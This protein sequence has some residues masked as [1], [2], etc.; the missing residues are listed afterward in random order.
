MIYRANYSHVAQ[1]HLLLPLLK[2]PNPCQYTHLGYRYGNIVGMDMGTT[3]NT[4]G[5]PVPFPKT[6]QSVG[7]AVE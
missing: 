3:C 6:E 2:L 4:H 1:L 5:L 7:Q